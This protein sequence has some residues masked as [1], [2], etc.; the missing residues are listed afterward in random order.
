[1]SENLTVSFMCVATGKRWIRNNEKKTNCFNVGPLEP[2]NYL[3]MRQ[4][5]KY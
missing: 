2:F 4:N 3:N 5:C 1:M